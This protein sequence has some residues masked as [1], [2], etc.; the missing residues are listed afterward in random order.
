MIDPQFLDVVR[1]KD[2]SAVH[3][4]LR[5]GRT[6]D[7]KRALY[8]QIA[9]SAFRNAAMRTEDIMIVLSENTLPDRSFGNGIA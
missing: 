6:G 1:G 5:T 2:A 7:Q 8:A 4:T 9:D 3:I